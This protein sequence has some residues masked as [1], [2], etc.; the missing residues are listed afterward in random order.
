MEAGS[1]REVAALYS[2]CYKQ[3]PLH[4]YLQGAHFRPFITCQD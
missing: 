3:V 1:F 2:D 4:K